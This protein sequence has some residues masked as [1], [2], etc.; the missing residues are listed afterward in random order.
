M[1]VEPEV[2]IK[3][4]FANRGKETRT[5]K[6]SLPVVLSELSSV[7][8]ARSEEEKTFFD[9]EFGMKNHIQKHVS[10]LAEAE[11]E[12]LSYFQTT[13]LHGARIYG[14]DVKPKICRTSC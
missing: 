8:S 12:M 9:L 14:A 1:S 13:S 3:R 6:E 7:Y 5:M 2:G 11:K 10:K 4:L